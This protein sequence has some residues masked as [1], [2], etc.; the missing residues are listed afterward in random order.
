MGAVPNRNRNTNAARCLG[1]F[2]FIAPEAA[3][4]WLPLTGDYTHQGPIPAAI[5]ALS[6]LHLMLP[7]LHLGLKPQR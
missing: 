5:Q 4:A 7:I 1:G 6:V 3:F 2:F